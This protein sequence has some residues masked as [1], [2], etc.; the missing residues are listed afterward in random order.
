MRAR[1]RSL[2]SSRFRSSS[3][4]PAS[5]ALMY[6]SRTR[7]SFSPSSSVCGEIVRHAARRGRRHR[8]AYSK[9]RRSRPHGRVRRGLD[10]TSIS[11]LNETNKKTIEWDFH[12]GAHTI[13]SLNLGS[14]AELASALRARAAAPALLFDEPLR[15][16]SFALA[17]IVCVGK[18]T[19]WMA[20]TAKDWTPPPH[21]QYHTCHPRGP[22][23]SCQGRADL[24]PD[25]RLQPCRPRGGGRRR[26]AN[27]T[28]T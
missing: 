2:P 19:S 16:P 1:P 14:L 9:C 21:S 3:L 25:N 27:E 26:A 6:S 18:K 11:R 5:S 12:T 22:E 20:R 24:G 23:R 13:P 10:S 17:I 4:L 8:V 7:V 28:V 15:Y